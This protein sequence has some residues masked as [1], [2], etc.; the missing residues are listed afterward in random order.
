MATAKEHIDEI[1]RT[2]FSIGGDLNPLT[3][4]LHQAV[5]NLSAELYAKDVHF[6]ME[7]IQNAE[8]NEY[9]E[10]V[11]SSLEFI[12]TS[13][14]ITVT[15]ASSTL[16]IFNNEKGFSRRNID[17][18]CS[19]GRSTKK[20]NR[21]RGYIGEKGI[22]FK[23]VFLITSRPYIFSNGYQIRFHE[24]PCPHCNVGYI[25][26]EWVDESPTLSDIRKIYGSATLPTTVMVLPLK[27]DKVKPVKH[28]L[29][30]IHPQVLLFLTK[31][32][33]L[34]VREDNE[35]P[36]LNTVNEIAISSETNFVQRKNIDAESYTLHLSAEE[37]GGENECHY[38]MWKQ[39]FP[40]RQENRVEKRQGVEEW[41]ITL[42]FPGGEPLQRGTKSPGMVTNFPFIIQ[43]DFLLASSRETILLDN[44]WNKGILDCVPVAFVKAFETFVK[45][46][47]PVSNLPRMFRFLPVNSSNFQEL[48]VVREAIKSKLI[49]EEIVPSETQLPQR[50]FHKPREVGR[51]MPAFWNILTK[52]REQGVSL[53][54]LSSH[55]KYIL[56]DSFDREEYD[57]ILNFLGVEPVDSE[58]Y[59][60]C[61]QSS[62]L[63]EEVSED[64]YLELL[65]FLADNWRSTFHCTNIKNIPLLKY[66]N[67]GGGLSF[68]SINGSSTGGGAS[69]IYLCP[70]SYGSDR[71][72][73]LLDWNKEFRS[74]ANH[75]FVPKVTQEAIRSYSK[76][77]TLTQWLKDHAKIGVVDM[78]DYAVILRK[79]LNNER[80]ALVSYV[81]LLYHSFLKKDY[82]SWR[83][84]DSLFDG[85][86]LIDSYGYDHSTRHGA[87]VPAEGSKWAGLVVSN[88][89]KGEGYIELSEDYLKAGRLAGKVITKEKELIGFLS[90]HSKAYD[91][92]LIPPPNSRIPAVSAP[93]T[94]ENAF[95][96]LKW[97]R[98][99]RG[100]IPQ[101]FLTCIKEG[102]WLKITLSGC[103]GSR[104]PS[105][106]F[107]LTSSLGNVL[108]N[109][110]VFVDIPLVDE[111]YY[112]VEI[113][114]YKEELRTIGVMSECGEACEFIGKHLMSLAASYTLT[115]SNVISILN[116]IKFLRTNYLPAD[117]FISNIQNGKWLRTSCGDRAPVEAVLYDKEWKTAS[118]ISDIPFIDVD[119]H[120]E[121]VCKFKTELQLLG[122]VVAYNGS[123]QLIVDHLKGPFWF[124]LPADSIILLLQCIR[125]AESSER[126]VKA[127]KG[128]KCLKTQA[129]F[130]SPD[131]CVLCDPEWD[132]LLQVFNGIPLIHGSFY[133]ESIFSYKNELKQIGVVVDFEAATGVFTRCFKERAKKSSI[134][135]ENVMT[136][137]SCYRVLSL[138]FPT[139]LKSCIREEN[140]LRTR[141]GDYRSPRDCILFGPE[142]ESISP[143]SLLP[144]IDDSENYYGKYI[145]EYK[146]ELKSMGVVLDFKDGVKFV[147]TRLHLKN[148]SEIS[149]ANA[150]ALL[151]CI[152]ILLKDKNFTFPEAFSKIVSQPWLKTHAGY[153]SPSQ[154]LLFDT[155]CSLKPT[156]GPFIDETHYGFK[157]A[158]YKKE[159]SAIGVIVD[160]EKGCP[161]MFNQLD[162]LSETSTIVRIYEYL[163][164]HNWKP[165]SEAARRI[166]IPNGRWASPEKCVISDKSGLFG[167]RLTVLDK[168][169]TGPSLAY[170]SWAFQVNPS[171]CLDDYCELWKFWET[172][173]HI[174]SH[175]DCCK[176]WGYVIKHWNS[177]TEK[178]LAEELVKVPVSS[179]SDSI[180]MVN[181]HDAFIPDDLQLKEL[182]E[183]SSRHPIFVWYREPSLPSFPWTKLLEIFQRIGV[184]NISESVQREDLSLANVV[185]SEEPV[186]RDHFIGKGLLKLILGYLSNPTLAME[187]EKRH[188]AVESLLDL[189]VVETVE[190]IHVSYKLSM[191]SGKTLNV[192]ASPM[193]LWERES[194]M[195][196]TQKID[197]SKGAG[198]LIEH[199][200]CFS[201][202]ISQ[203]LLWEHSDNI[204][205]LS[206]LLTSAFLL[207]FNEEVV[208]FLMKSKNLQTFMVD[209]DII[210]SVFPS[211]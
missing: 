85:T 22:G 200:T 163:C 156:D 207:E 204:D 141:L 71:I 14:D 199:A 148:P 174:L 44:K 161:L 182:F 18:I 160:I 210:S 48:N 69:L 29:S 17:S 194:S 110:S 115:R 8:D 73:W 201:Q 123:H 15:G 167:L 154:S 56:S 75:Y 188:K 183:K 24:D 19:V 65:Q 140:W 184:R 27:A 30:N 178:T 125:R 181:K 136:F 95:V 134:S 60:K 179:G 79:S 37:N 16:L 67:H 168:H 107:M 119:H 54:H 189:T 105:Q 172:S 53:L 100:S 177:K 64:V 68:R 52:A 57:Q 101:T 158:S 139:D 12:V 40:V 193:V 78:Y 49:V 36:L 82:L 26:P 197:R 159:L 96:L 126:V 173:D 166:W 51:L 164:Q 90:D 209:E 7:L 180:R 35:N 211:K 190:P 116:F 135:K 130:K 127:L 88:V 50:F 32:K 86:P 38:F 208:S 122:V 169:Y 55:G 133:G 2:K 157:M 46:P 191:S 198:N 151:D 112:G 45:A 185:E 203:G 147:A 74:V 142:W 87:L 63:V 187:V 81:H 205:A 70:H 202:A 165:E 10:G 43:A 72:M 170:F 196:F 102:S 176:F 120:G 98:K 104:P 80:K 11:D 3:E 47:G 144:F 114:D 97:I 28:Q 149:P 131:E 66:E 89:W 23:S 94:K 111:N 175:D 21:K 145:H 206:A 92:P 93:L 152:Q 117:K 103:P 1:R 143:I 58:W 137:L 33:R 5:K 42:A 25:V 41:V 84:F 59:A 13:R 106:S 91:I 77:E 138:K 31:I 113:K 34:S 124:S 109:G 20:G 129:G 132:C 83:Q 186:T 76:K 39:K 128:A 192:K 195:I 150:L 9:S 146:K 155:K 162:F 121:E 62:L 4:D 99:F 171:P 153:R 108:Q 118:E 61:I 6:L